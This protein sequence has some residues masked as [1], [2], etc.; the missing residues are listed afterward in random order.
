MFGPHIDRMASPLPKA[1]M[2][3]D[4][5]VPSLYQDNLHF[6]STSKNY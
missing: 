1:F 6:T 5:P 3:L 4:I 2:D